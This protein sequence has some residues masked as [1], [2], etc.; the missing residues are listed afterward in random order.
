MSMKSATKQFIGRVTVALIILLTVGRS[1]AAE[2]NQATPEA[3][4][5]P[6]P[7]KQAFFFTGGTPLD[8]VLAMDHHFR[9]RLGEILSIPSSLAH[10][11]VPKMRVPTENP[12]DALALYNRLDNP[13]LGR[14]YW[15]PADPNGGTNM[16]V[17]TLVPNRGTPTEKSISR[18]KAIALGGVPEDKWRAL[19]EDV[20]VAQKVGR[21]DAE[22]RGSENP[23]GEI[24]IQPAS[25]VLIVSGSD[26][27]IEMVES[28][29][30]AHRIN[31]DISGRKTGDAGK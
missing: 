14:W 24:H 29:V 23:E 26:A 10:A 12:G 30:A 6:K 31:A 21:N 11:Q 18:V 7:K 25:K 28:V 22:R 20:A 16:H 19:E 4:S 1:L 9:T 3:K 15:D 17:L 13:F 27:F 5:E 8:F 2:T